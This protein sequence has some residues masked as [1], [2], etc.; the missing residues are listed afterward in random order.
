MLV[1]WS[2]PYKSETQGCTGAML[3]QRRRQWPNIAPAQA[4]PVMFPVKR[5]TLGINQ[6]IVQEPPVLYWI[7][8]TE[9]SRYRPWPLLL[10]GENMKRRPNVGLM[11][12]QFRRPWTGIKA[13]WYKPMQPWI[14]YVAQCWMI[15][16]PALY[17]DNIFSWEGLPSPKSQSC[18][19]NS[20]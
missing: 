1:K 7:I 10:Y 9:M 2:E 16:V 19:N 5:V 18:Y 6:P 17:W 4:E 8:Q 20:Q 13:I 15:A 3:G 12:G 11:L 14:K